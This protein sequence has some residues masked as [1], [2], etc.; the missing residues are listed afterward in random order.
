MAD[1]SSTLPDALQ[2]FLRHCA[3]STLQTDSIKSAT[4]KIVKQALSDILEPIKPGRFLLETQSIS[5]KNRVETVE[6]DE[7]EQTPEVEVEEDRNF[8]SALQRQIREG[9]EKEE[10]EEEEEEEGGEEEE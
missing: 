10:E 3:Q 5:R 9:Q 2:D 4:Q 6:Q 8:D 1:N 7:E